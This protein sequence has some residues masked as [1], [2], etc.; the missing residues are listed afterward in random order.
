[1]DARLQRS[2]RARRFY[3]AVLLSGWM[4]LALAQPPAVAPACDDSA[5]QPRLQVRVA[6]L[7]N[8]KGNITITVY[9]DD[10][11]RFLAK[12]GKLARQRV[13]AVQPET[14]ACFS[15]P[16]AGGY[17]IAVYHDANDDHDFNRNFVG[18]PTEGFG[19]SRNPKTVLGLPRFSEVRFV[20]QA[21][22]NPVQITLSY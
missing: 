21:G 1:M 13:P 17:A 3:L 22:D 18:R 15:L 6:G 14:T 9:P 5:G 8:A 11:S 2:S 19:F 16:T 4:G 10:A 12:G 20:A 7:K